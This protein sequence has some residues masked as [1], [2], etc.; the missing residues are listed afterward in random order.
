MFSATLQKEYL[1]G[2]TVWQKI[3]RT[4]IRRWPLKCGDMTH[5]NYRRKWSMIA[6]ALSLRED[7]DERVE[8]DRNVK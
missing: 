7:T 5:E 2:M 8:R 3:Y 1:S 6:L 4:Q